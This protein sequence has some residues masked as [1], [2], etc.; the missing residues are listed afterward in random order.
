MVLILLVTQ[1]L[2]EQFPPSEALWSRGGL[3]WK[4][5]ERGGGGEHSF[6]FYPT[7]LVSTF[8]HCTKD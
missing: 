5:P 7:A 1:Q 4:D 3:E 6:F 8:Y 2:Q